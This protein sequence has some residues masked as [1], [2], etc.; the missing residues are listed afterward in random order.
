MT[1]AAADRRHARAVEGAIEAQVLVEQMG[2]MDNAEDIRL[3]RAEQ[4]MGEAQQQLATVG[5]IDRLEDEA[6]AK[7]AATLRDLAGCLDNVPALEGA[8]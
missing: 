1:A 5:R 6:R 4:L 3:A 2:R 7:L 8:R